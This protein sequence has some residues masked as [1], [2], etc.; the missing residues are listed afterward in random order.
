[1]TL[2]AYTIPCPEHC[3]E[4]VHLYFD[5]V[6]SLPIQWEG[7]RNVQIDPSACHVQ[8]D[9]RLDGFAEAPVRVQEGG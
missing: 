4:D 7:E 8:F 3:A 2:R 6:T 1:M 9:G 5:Y